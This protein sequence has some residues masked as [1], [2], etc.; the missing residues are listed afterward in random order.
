MNEKNKRSLSVIFTKSGNDGI[1]TRLTLPITWIKELNIT[2]TEREV[3]VYLDLELKRIIIEKAKRQ[4][5]SSGKK[6]YFVVYSQKEF[7]IGKWEEQIGNGIVTLGFPTNPKAKLIEPGD[8]IILYEKKA[9]LRGIY[10]VLPKDQW[11]KVEKKNFKTE[12]QK[13][14]GYSFSSET[15]FTMTPVCEL[16]NPI[17]FRPFLNQLSFT[18]HL[19]SNWNGSIQGHNGIKILLESDVNILKNA[20]ELAKQNEN[21]E[22]ELE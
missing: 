2:E 18:K 9:S 20:L 1:S 22:K 5:F 21:I 4:E 8:E 7:F 15:Q 13:K 17:D 3:E 16:A 10:R 12:Y 19:G 14:Y 6:T 11:I